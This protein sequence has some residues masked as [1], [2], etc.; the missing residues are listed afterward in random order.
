VPAVDKVAARLGRKSA[1]NRSKCVGH[2]RIE[3]VLGAYAFGSG[4]RLREARYADC[5]GSG[6]EDEGRYEQD[7][8]DDQ[9]GVLV[10]RHYAERNV[11]IV[12]SKYQRLD[13]HV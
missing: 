6:K 9:P 1:K 4:V 10:V 2:G 13:V 12:Q 7:A 3:V 8:G 11:C 5:S